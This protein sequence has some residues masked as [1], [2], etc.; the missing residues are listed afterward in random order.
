[1]TFGLSDYLRMLRARGPRLPLAHFRQAH[2]FDLL[3]GTDTHARRP[4]ATGPDQPANAAH[5]VFYMASWTNV[6]K[7]ATRQA[8]SRLN[9]TAP[10]IQ[11]TDIGCGKGK[12]L[13][14]WHQMFGPAASLTGLDY[15]RALLDICT[16]NLDKLGAKAA[17]NHCDATEYSF[18]TAKPVTLIYL[19]NPFDAVILSQVARNLSG[20]QC[21]VIYNNPVHLD[22]LT[23]AGFK[24]F[25]T[26]DAWH[27]NAQ[28]ALLT[29]I[30]A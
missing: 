6:I 8:M 30:A 3:N 22:T 26:C 18:V 4:K 11:F 23:E 10:D 17:L 28:Y 12:T 27:P 7:T 5:G 15:D 9:L 1:M 20:V 25:H 16:T 19:Y 21:V 24:L 13:C 14:V 29:N 2:V